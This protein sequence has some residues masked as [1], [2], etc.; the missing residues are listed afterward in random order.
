VIDDVGD[1][2]ALGVQL[3]VSLGHPAGE[4]ASKAK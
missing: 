3:V 2:D 4:L 1:F